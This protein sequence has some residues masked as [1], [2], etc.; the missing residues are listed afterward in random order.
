MGPARSLAGIASVAVA[1]LVMMALLPDCASACSCA[2][3][4]GTPQE[5]VGEALSE[6]TAVFS[7]KVVEID[8]PS[9]PLTSSIAP[10][11]VTFRVSESWKGPERDTLEVKTPVSGASCGYSFRS[12]EGYLVYA[13]EASMVEAEGL[14]VLLCGETKPLSEAGA[15][16]EVLGDGETSKDGGVLS[17]T[18]GG[19]P[20]HAMAGLAGVALATSFLLA[21]RLLRT[22]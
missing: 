18:S 8:R 22:G 19:V 20:A 15:D 12:G 14:E 5:R 4:P 21:M 13:S 9:L 7:G 3:L 6:S 2:V 17:D 11:T 1:A 16:L 10:E